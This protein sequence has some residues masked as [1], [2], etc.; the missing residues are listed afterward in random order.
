M[1]TAD[2]RGLW[3]TNAVTG[4]A[5]KQETELSYS[6]VKSKLAVESTVFPLVGGR[7]CRLKKCERLPDTDSGVRGS[8]I[9]IRCVGHEGDGRVGERM[10]QHG[11]GGQDPFPV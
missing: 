2:T 3:S 6:E 10:C 8:V 11:C 7:R 5:W 1:F 4:Q 9:V